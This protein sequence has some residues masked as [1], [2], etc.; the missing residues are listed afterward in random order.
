MYNQFWLAS[1]C[2]A[3][4]NSAGRAIARSTS[5]TA[6]SHVGQEA[7][8]FT[9]YR[10]KHFQIGAGYGYFVPGGFLRRTTP[11]VG[12]TYLYIFHTYSL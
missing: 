9:V 1:S 2:D 7:D 6:G 4:Y 12:P 5:C 8:V 11:G 3:L 10:Y